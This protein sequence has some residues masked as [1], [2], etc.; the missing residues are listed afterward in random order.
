MQI[1]EKRVWLRS[2]VCNCNCNV[3]VMWVKL[4]LIMPFLT[5][6]HICCPWWLICPCA[7]VLL[8]ISSCLAFHVHMWNVEEVSEH[9]HATKYK[10]QQMEMLILFWLTALADIYGREEVSQ[11][12][13]NDSF[14]FFALI[15]TDWDLSICGNHLQTVQ[16]FLCVNKENRHLQML[17]S[18]FVWIFCVYRDWNERH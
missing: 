9:S 8:L 12:F 10:L 3:C 11:I 16:Q 7:G 4:L 1:T 2:V 14:S 17:Q 15:S 5:P 6:C 13:L 18:L